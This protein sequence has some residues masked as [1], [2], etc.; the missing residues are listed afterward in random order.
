MSFVEIER[1]FDLPD[2]VSLPALEGAGEERQHHLVAAYHDTPDFRLWRAGITLR[3][4]LG[5]SDPGWHLK[6]SLAAGGRAEHHAPIGATRVPVALR[7]LVDEVISRAPLVEVAVL[8]NRRTEI[9]IL[10]QTGTEVAVV[11]LDRVHARVGNRMESWNE[12]EVELVQGSEDVLD[13][14]EQQL[15]AAG[16]APDRHGSKVGHALALLA[17]EGFGLPGGSAGAVIGSYLAKQVGVL[18]SRETDVR[19]DVPDAVHRSRVATR[20]LRSA[21]R[22]FGRLYRRKRLRGLRDEL[23]WHAERLGAPRDAEVLAERL[24]AALDELPQSQLSAGVRDRLTATLAAEHRAAH[25]ELV[26]SMDA[27]RYDRLHTALAGLLNNPPGA[28]RASLMAVDVLPAMQAAAMHR[29]DLMA[30]QA[31]SDPDDLVHWHEVRK[32]SKA[33]R[34]GAES[35]TDAF[36]EPA[37]RLAKAWEAV[38][39]AFGEVQD[40]VVAEELLQRFTTAAAASGE[41]VQPYRALAELEERRRSE[42]LAE[43]RLALKQAQDPGLRSWTAS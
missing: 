38:T 3:R 30:E 10:D 6:R 33:A 5:G 20:R 2:G 8:T 24:G 12:V 19:A 40:T 22:T 36:G 23:A 21:L 11:C 29:V 28:K 35:L 41:D 15:L 18:Q 17:Q 13:R 42:A 34:Y 16:L 14:I 39:E 27:E 43:G 32:A 25:A 4:R 1:K 26:T 9:P 37:E 7:S 31:E